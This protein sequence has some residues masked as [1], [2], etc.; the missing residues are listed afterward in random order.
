LSR[1]ILSF[2]SSPRDS[3]LQHPIQIW[4]PLSC[5]ILFFLFFS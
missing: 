5:W 4:I 2:L 3:E 1:W